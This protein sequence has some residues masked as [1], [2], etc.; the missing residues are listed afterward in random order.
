MVLE[1]YENATAAADC[2]LEEEREE[3]GAAEK[4]VVGAVC[5]AFKGEGEDE[6]GGEAGGAV[7][8]LAVGGEECR[9]EAAGEEGS[10]SE[11]AAGDGRHEELDM[12]TANNKR[13]R[14]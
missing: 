10:Q 3:Q 4:M 5:P 13:T 2:C 11:P 6:G 12:S 8:E 9:V 7:V 14:C 1:V